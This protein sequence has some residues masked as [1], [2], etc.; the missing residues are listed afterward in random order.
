MGRI[1]VNSLATTKEQVT[2]VRLYY[3]NKHHYFANFPIPYN[4]I[5]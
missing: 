1:T 4:N 5:I 2:K 3:D